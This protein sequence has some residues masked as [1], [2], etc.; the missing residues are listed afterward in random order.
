MAMA[1]RG[2]RGAITVNEN[3]A[4]AIL[5]GAH[6]LVKTMMAHNG[7]EVGELASVVFTATADLNAAYPA[8]AAREM[9]WTET[10]LLCMQEMAVQGSLAKC[11]RVLIHWNTERSAAEIQHVYL[12]GAQVLRPDLLGG[13]R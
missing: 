7:F 10:P 4:E 8:A 9:G 2:V 11:I 5:E 13:E 1:C 3:S 6:T 12:R